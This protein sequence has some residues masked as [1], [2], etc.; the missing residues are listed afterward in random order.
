[1]TLLFKVINPEGMGVM[2]T[3]AWSCIPANRVLESMNATGYKF[4]LDG[5][6]IKLRELIEVRD[7]GLKAERA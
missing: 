2:Q 1:M 7:A 5:K 4:M 3:A 6:R